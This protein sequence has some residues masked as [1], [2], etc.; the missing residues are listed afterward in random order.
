MNIAIIMH[1]RTRSIAQFRLAAAMSSAGG[2]LEGRKDDGNTTDYNGRLNSTARVTAIAS[3]RML[4]IANMLPG[5][6]FTRAG[7]NRGLIT[8]TTSR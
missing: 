1:A 7:C 5:M 3:R 2:S 4:C 8:T 6:E